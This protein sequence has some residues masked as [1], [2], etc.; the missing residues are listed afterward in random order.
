MQSWADV[1]CQHSTAACC[2]E[3]RDV[4]AAGGHCKEQKERGDHRIN[5]SL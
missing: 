2:R 3:H 1:R 5:Y 4:V